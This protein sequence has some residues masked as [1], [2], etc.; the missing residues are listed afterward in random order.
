MN[1]VRVQVLKRACD[2]EYSERWAI[3]ITLTASLQHHQ[4]Q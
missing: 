4:K 3:D 2:S 1:S